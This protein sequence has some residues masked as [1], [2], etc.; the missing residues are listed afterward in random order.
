MVILWYNIFL[1]FLT[2][3][4]RNEVSLCY[5]LMILCQLNNNVYDLECRLLNSIWYSCPP[6]TTGARSNPPPLGGAR[7]QFGGT[8][9]LARIRCF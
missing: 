8:G 9:I 5:V 3:R 6:H 1:V 4:G 7:Q 2:R